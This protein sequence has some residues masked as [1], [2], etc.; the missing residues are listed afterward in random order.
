MNYQKVRLGDLPIEWK[1]KGQG[2]R[3]S[4]INKDGKNRCVLYG[5][6]YTKHNN[7]KLSLIICPKLIQ[8]E[9]LCQKRRHPCSWHF[10]Q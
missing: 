6:L 8:L 9:M 5:E 4:D 1:K 2:F 7:T 3:K 10:N